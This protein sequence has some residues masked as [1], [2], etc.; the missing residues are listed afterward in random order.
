LSR[1]NANK[2]NVPSEQLEHADY[3][4]LKEK[5]AVD[6]IRAL[7]RWPDVFL[8]TVKVGYFA[9]FLRLNSS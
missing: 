7:A 3:T 1:V 9:H 2:A 6:L 8:N 4:L 5:H